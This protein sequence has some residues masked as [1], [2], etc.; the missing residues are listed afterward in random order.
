MMIVHYMTMSMYILTREVTNSPPRGYVHSFLLST[1][2]LGYYCITVH[3]TDDNEM[4]R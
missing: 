3:V 2:L 1:E 4:A